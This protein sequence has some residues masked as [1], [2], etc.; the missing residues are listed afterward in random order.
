MKM[1]FVSSSSVSSALRYSLLK[2]QSE[3]NKAQKEA[4]TGRVADT[5]LALGSQTAKSV[6]LARDLDRLNGIVD[7]NGLISA[8]LKATQSALTQL[9]DTAQTFLATLTANANG[10]AGAGVVLTDADATLDA[11]TSILNSTVD[12]E[13]LFAGINTDVRPINDYGATASPAKAAFDA[14]FLGHFGFSQNAPAAASISAADMTTFLDTVLEPQFMGAAWEANWSNATDDTIVSRIA[15]NETLNTSVS[16]NEAG[17]RKLAM[18]AVAVKEIFSSNA[19]TAARA[20]VVDKAMELTGDAIGEIGNLQAETGI[21]ENRV[22]NA[23]DRIATQIDLFERLQLELEGVDPYEASTRVSTLLGQIE[24]S[25][26][27]TARLQQL[28]LAKY[29]T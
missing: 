5:G 26:A 2:A 21:V 13:H 25:Y 6:S 19:G 14:A 1:S 24:T 22:T 9:G 23:S 16:A 20:A 15:L 27:L 10:D 7:S 4:S 18:A 28:S 3:L 12:G 29:L 17:L 8:R 11:F